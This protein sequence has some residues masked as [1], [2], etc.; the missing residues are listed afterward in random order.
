MGVVGLECAF[1]LLYTY[2]VK[3]NIISLEKLIELMHYNPCKR[4]NIKGGLEIGKPADLCVY[5]LEKQTI[6]NPESFLSKGRS[7]P[8]AEYKINS[9][10]KLTMCKGE[11]KWQENMIEK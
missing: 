10:C 11:I 7:T 8:F 2:L 6:V 4:F 3:E 9:E 1:P 5:D